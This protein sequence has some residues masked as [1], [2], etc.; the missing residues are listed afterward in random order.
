MKGRT[1]FFVSYE[2]IREKQGLPVNLTVASAAMKTGDFS[3]VRN[4][5]YDPLTGQPFPN[6]IIPANRLSPQALYF[7][8]FIPDPNVGT[9]NFTCLPER[10]LNADQVTLRVDH[11]LNEKAQGV[12]ALQL[13]RQPH[14][15][16][17]LDAG[18]ALPRLSRARPGAHPHARQNL[19][20]AVTS[21]FTPTVLNEFRFSY[22]PQVV[23]LE[24]F[25]LGT[26]YYQEAGV[27]GFEE[28]GRPGV[29]GSFPDFSWS[30]YSNMQGRRSTSVRRPRI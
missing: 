29:V 2:G 21:T 11:T 27:K 25:G 20:A 19:V 3:A 18:R 4:R 13:P 12:R 14:G 1:F 9:G 7:A 22:L 15:G 17:Q 26:N 10:A 24:P 28:T 23:D 8:E 16:P 5:I 6:N 30:G